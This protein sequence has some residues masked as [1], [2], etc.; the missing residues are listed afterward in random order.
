MRNG[1]LVGFDVCLDR[2]GV[3]EM[4]LSYS[5][6]CTV[7]ITNNFIVTDAALLFVLPCLFWTRRDFQWETSGI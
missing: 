6:G 4:R 2:V 1:K 3:V 7:S 5:V